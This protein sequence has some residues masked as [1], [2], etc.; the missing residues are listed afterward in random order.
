MACRPPVGALHM[1]H[2]H[3]RWC[4]QPLPARQ[5]ARHS[6]RKLPPQRVQH[7]LAATSAAQT[8]MLGGMRDLAEGTQ[9]AFARGNPEDLQQKGE[10]MLAVRRLLCRALI[11]LV[12]LSC[13]ELVCRASNYCICISSPRLWCRLPDTH[14]VARQSS[15]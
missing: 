12:V 2:M 9:E 15:R 6:R 7:N 13:Y 1:Q 10:D 5:Q 3:A 4:C 11:Y 14:I 8:D